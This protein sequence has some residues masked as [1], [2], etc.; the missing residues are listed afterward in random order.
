M[1]VGI[2]VIGSTIKR[3]ATMFKSAECGAT[4]V[5]RRYATQVSRGP[6]F[7]E[8]NLQLLVQR[9]QDKMQLVMGFL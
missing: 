3:T 8:E 9:K 5:P 4:V 6:R 7:H 2:H 1:D